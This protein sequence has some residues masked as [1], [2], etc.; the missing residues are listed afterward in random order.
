[1]EGWLGWTL[2]ILAVLAALD[3]LALWLERRG[4]LYYRHR[5]P[6]SGPRTAMLALQSILEP[7]K[8]HVVESQR[9]SPMLGEDD[10]SGGPPLP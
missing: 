4:W 7:D 9:Q 5:R 8:Q 6:T 10:E 2:A 1:M 3:R